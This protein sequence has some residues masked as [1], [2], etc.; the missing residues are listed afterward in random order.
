MYLKTQK[1]IIENGNCMQS[2]ETVGLLL[3]LYPLDNT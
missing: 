1:E 2:R 3:V